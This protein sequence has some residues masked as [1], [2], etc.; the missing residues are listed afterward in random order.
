MPLVSAVL[1]TSGFVSLMFWRRSPGIAVE[2]V[3]SF[4]SLYRRLY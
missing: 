2:L 3:G 1:N 4:V